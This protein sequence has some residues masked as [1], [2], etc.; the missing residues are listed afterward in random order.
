VDAKCGGCLA[1]VL[2]MGLEYAQNII[3]FHILK[4]IPTASPRLVLNG[5]CP[6]GLRQILRGDD[7]VRS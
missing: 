4:G 2:M 3:L 7:G 5:C 6:D 1:V